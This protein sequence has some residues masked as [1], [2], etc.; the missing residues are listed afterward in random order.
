MTNSNPDVVTAWALALQGSTFKHNE[1]IMYALAD[2][3]DTSAQRVE[4]SLAAA[5][6]GDFVAVEVRFTNLMDSTKLHVQPHL[7]AA[8]CVTQR[9]IT[10]AEMFGG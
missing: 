7:W 2:N 10:A 3:S 5:K 9:T 6:P 4:A 1:M 8:W